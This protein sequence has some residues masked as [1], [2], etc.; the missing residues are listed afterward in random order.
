MPLPRP[1]LFAALLCFAVALCAFGAIAYSQTSVP[2]RRITVTSEEGINLNPSISGD[3]LTL[4]FEST[5][6]VARV[7]GS[8]RFRALRARLDASPTS[9][10]QM[11]ATRAPA[12]AISQTGAI[13]AF[14]ALDDPL[15]TNADG[16]SEIFFF[17]AA[18]SSLRQVTN[19]SPGDTALRARNGNFQP[20]ISDDGRFI[21]FASNRDLTNANPDFNFE[22]FLYDSL[23]QTFTQVTNTS[24]IIG[25]VDAKISGNSA[26]IA[27]IRD[28][29]A[30]PDATTPVIT[31]S[32][33]RDLLT[34]DRNTSITRTTAPSVSNLEFT[35]GRAISDD[36]TRVVYA[37]NTA[38]NASQ[39][40]L[41]DDRVGGVVRQITALG[42]R[43][44]D[45]PLHA[46]ISGDGLRITFATRRTVA[47]TGT[48]SDGSVELYAYDL[49]TAQ[50][51]R[52]TNVSSSAAIGE[53][54]SSLSDDG[55]RV[56]FNFPRV[57]SGAVVN[58]DFANNSEIYV[59]ELAARD[60]FSNNLIVLNGASFGREP[61]PTKAIAPDSIAVARGN[62]LALTTTQSARQLDATFPRSVAGTTVTV[63]NRS[64]QIF[65]VSPTQVNF[66]VPPET[67]VGQAQVTVT[68][69]DSFQT[70]GT[71]TVFR[72][73]PGTF[74]ASGDGQG[75]AVALDAV[76]LQRG[77]FDPVDAQGNPRRVIIFT[78]GVRNASSVTVTINNR[79]V[80]ID[81]VT[82]S[83]DMPGLDQ[84][85]VVLDPQLS[86][87]GTVP[88]IVRADERESNTTTITLIGAPRGPFPVRVEITP[89]NA[90]INR[91]G[92]QQFVARAFD[93]SGAQITGVMFA[94]TSSNNAIAT[95]DSN[96][97]ARGVGFGATTIRASLSDGRG[98][99]IAGEA[100]LN[101]VVPLV[102][103]EILADVPLDSA[104]TPEI[105]GDANRDRVRDSDDDE[106][107]E[108]VNSSSAPVDISGLRVADSTSNRFTFPANTLLRA[109]QAAIVFGG[110]SPPPSDPAFGGSLLFT[111]TTL[112][113]ANTGDTVTVRIPVASGTEATIVSVTYGAEADSDQSLTRSPDAE[114]GT[115]GGGFVRHI[116]ATNADGR[117]FSPGTR[118]DGTP[119]G[120]PPVTRIEVVPSSASINVGATQMFTARAFS[121]AGGVEIE[122]Q[123]VSFIWSSSETTR[124]AFATR[125]GQSTTL[126]GIGAGN[127]TISARAGGQ[128]GA[129]TLTVNSIVA[130]IELTPETSSVNVGNTVTFTATA[131]DAGGAIIPDIVFAFSLRNASPPNAASIVSTTANTVTVRGNIV[132]T[133]TVVASYTRPSD[134]ITL[135][136]TSALTIIP[137]F[138]C[139][140]CSS[141]RT[142]YH[143]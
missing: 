141:R 142:N 140:T 90:T 134:G 103:N 41:F 32:T 17:D 52:I 16:N 138:V 74:T 135:E 119:F 120:S 77:P 131:R 18:T 130:T 100:T 70:R 80:A 59:A 33:Q 13:I 128:S 89:S 109:G 63:N 24:G 133:V 6:D 102:I 44:E 139:A 87:A 68:N 108:L 36:G 19:T 137:S 79:Q 110:G 126:T 45:V 82:P 27:F 69:A 1:R 127:V 85:H 96:G 122:I 38:Q 71:V 4:A 88:L 25:S 10:T 67:E 94:W 91:G 35:Y 98:G 95:I 105:E 114:V 8:E 123:N 129:A 21:A 121:N 57:L 65:Y 46:T 39:V 64:A 97:F 54:V 31:F 66:L 118:A 111:A 11:A 76:T 116:D 29:G 48:N 56:A 58:P 143:Q 92:A 12:S 26:R 136:D 117:V 14:A 104:S 3:G 47:G 72:A 78:T 34:F 20:S 51:L 106:F 42:A 43:S 73:A 2:V 55:T 40:F 101:V 81:I 61:S 53:V 28:N 60:N 113:L 49:P 62:N 75:E 132:G 7:G 15:G 115:T 50:T 9:F 86:G 5:E 37:A 107:I 124:V 22:I 30:P 93:V 112:S 99:T 23:T 83:R 125:T 84:I